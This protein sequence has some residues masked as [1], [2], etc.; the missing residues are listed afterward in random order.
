[1]VLDEVQALLP[2]ANLTVGLVTLPEARETGAVA[3]AVVLAA[4]ALV[5]TALAVALAGAALRA[6]AF[7][8]VEAVFLV[9]RAV[10]VAGAD[11]TAADALRPP[12]AG[13][14]LVVLAAAVRAVRV[15]RAVVAVAR[16]AAARPVPAGALVAATFFA[17]T[18]R[19]AAFFELSA[20]LKPAAGLKRMPLEAGILTGWPVR[21][22][23]PVRALRCV[24]LK[25]PKP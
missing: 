17:A 15:A 7:A 22:L 3:L 14:A 11:F 13:A 24:G 5:L 1:V 19:P 9:E 2:R 20:S 8:T 21:G 12:L 10:V 23:R 16:E 25:L 6:G 4:K 18:F